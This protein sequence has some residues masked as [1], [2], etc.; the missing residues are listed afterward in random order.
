MPHPANTVPDYVRMSRHEWDLDDDGHEVIEHAVAVE[1]DTT[2]RLAPDGAG[3]VEFA[4][5]TGGVSVLD[6]LT[7]VTITSPVAGHRLRYNGSVWVNTTLH[8]QVLIDGTGSV[9]FDGTGAPVETEVL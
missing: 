7:D 9:V 6:D 2:L 5:T 8:I 3:G 1:T 4:V